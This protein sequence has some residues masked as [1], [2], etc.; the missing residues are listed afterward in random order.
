MR[1]DPK[2]ML[3]TT[4]QFLNFEAVGDGLARLKL[5]N[6]WKRFPGVVALK[7]VT[8]SAVAGEVHAL[9][10][11]NGAGKSTLM[12]VASGDVRP[13]EGTIEL[14]GRR[15]ERL[16]SAQAQRLGLAI[17]HQHPAVLPDLTVAENM[18][19]AVPRSLRT[20]SGRGK[21]W[22]ADQLE[23]V[24]CTV[25]P[26]YRM[27]NVDI[28]Q[29]HLIELAKA[30]SIEPKILILDEPTAPL[31]SDLVDLLFEKVRAAAARGARP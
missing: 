25:H 5:H 12:G 29:R 23:R 17:V 16:T 14:C 15:I 31:T 4:E 3:K 24:G 6:V 9:L 30:L 20:G 26:S 19:L 8:F 13:D 7:D 11:E 22:V 27:A 10:G 28:A 2:N 21:A 1:F 18:L